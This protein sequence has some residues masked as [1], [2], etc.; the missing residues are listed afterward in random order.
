VR[1]LHLPAHGN[2]RVMLHKDTALLRLVSARLDVAYSL[3]AYGILTTLEPGNELLYHVAVSMAV[4]YGRP[5]T[6]S[7]GV[8]SLFEEYPHFPDFADEEMNLRHHRLIDLRNKFMAHSSCEG[9]KVLI[10]P[11]GCKNPMTGDVVDRYDHLV[12]KRSFGDVRFYEWL[13]DV[14]IELRRRLDAD[15]RKRLAEMYSHVKEPIEMATGY[16]DFKW[17]IPKKG[18]T[19]GKKTT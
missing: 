14:A 4:S 18:S 2:G 8:G 15:V 11:P 7:N 10:L 12:G 19:G 6:A 17:T 16:D 13:K 9:T 1:P 5:F 3:E